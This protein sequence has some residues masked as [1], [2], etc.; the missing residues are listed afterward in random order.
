V[1]GL[2]NIQEFGDAR[3]WA[4]RLLAESE[5]RAQAWQTRTPS[6]GKGAISPEEAE[7][8]YGLMLSV[9]E[10]MRAQRAAL[11]RAGEGRGPE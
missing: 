6:T 7:K 2:Q 4:D 5:R 10:L 8:T 11:L 9:I 1:T 3:A